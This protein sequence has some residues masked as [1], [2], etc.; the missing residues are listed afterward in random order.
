MACS[1][2]G[3]KSIRKT[4]RGSSRKNSRYLPPDG[5]GGEG[6]RCG[7]AVAAGLGGGDA[8][9]FVPIRVLESSAP[10]GVAIHLGDGRVIC[11]RPGFDRQTLR[12]VLAA[13]EGEPC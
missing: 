13:V 4:F 9:A 11:V 10:A 5:A 12:D 1:S 2:D 7:E 6:G 3:P 8:S